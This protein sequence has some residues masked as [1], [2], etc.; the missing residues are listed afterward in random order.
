MGRGTTLDSVEME[1]LVERLW[2]KTACS[3]CF[4]VESR[5]LTPQCTYGPYH[6]FE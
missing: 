5:G 3:L 4:R 6:G 2:N 1:A